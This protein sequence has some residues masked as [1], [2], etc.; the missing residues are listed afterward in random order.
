VPPSQTYLV[1]GYD[2]L[3]PPCH[4]LAVWIVQVQNSGP[5]KFLG[6]SPATI[7]F[8]PNEQPAVLRDALGDPQSINPDVLHA[9]LK[10]APDA[11]VQID[12]QAFETVANR[13]GGVFLEGRTLRGQDV[14]DVLGSEQSSPLE[15]LDYEA[16]VLRA[17]A[18][19][20]PPGPEAFILAGLSPAHVR[21]TIPLDRLVSENES[22]LPT[23]GTHIEVDL[24]DNVSS[25][26]LPGG[27]QGLLPN[28]P[29]PNPL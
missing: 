6:L 16:Q 14:V 19:R 20:I 5:A 21:S 23:L 13:L 29:L 28:P 15:A 10:S 27:G 26:T 17:L 2:Q 1:L 4:L 12:N 25:F 9:Y 3:T 18:L 7:I 24:L 22:R 8:L 11:V